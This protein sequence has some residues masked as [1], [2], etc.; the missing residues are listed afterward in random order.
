M[1]PVVN[2]PV[3]ELVVELLARQG[4]RDLHANVHY[5]ADEII[6]YFGEGRRWA[7]DL[8]YSREH[9]LA[10]TAGGL[11]LLEQHFRNDTFVVFSSDLLTDIELAP[12][13]A[14]HKRSGALATIALTRVDDPSSYG[15]VTLNTQGRVTGF[16]EKPARAEA[17][18][19]LINCGVYIFEPAV[20]DYIP[21]GRPFDFGSDLF[22]LLF[23]SGAALCGYEHHKYW[24]DIGRIENYRKGNFDAL[25]G[26]VHV[27]LPG[28]NISKGIWVGKDTQIHHSAEMIGPVSIGASCQIQKN[29]RIIGPVIIGNN[30]IINEGTLLQET[31]KM[32]NGH[33]APNVNMIGGIIGES[34]PIELVYT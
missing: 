34:R 14:F 3:M 4:L 31:I 13:I 28:H 10:G 22:P 15:V 11:K 12:M 19:N 2:K 26:K 21:S 24:L 27:N 18:S 16:Q 20:F 17:V 9:A 5:K 30:N 33:V 7:V 8:K 1:I 6:D 25:I 29:T 32:P 23:E